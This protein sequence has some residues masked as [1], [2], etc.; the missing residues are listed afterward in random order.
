MR[1]TKTVTMWDF[2]W[3]VRRSGNEAEYLDWD[4][5]IAELADRD[6]DVVRI[7]AFPH[8]IAHDRNGNRQETYTILPQPAGFMWGNHETVEVDPGPQL[9]EFMR[10]VHESGRTAALSTWF[11]DDA[12]NRAA[13]IE[14]PADYERIWTETL[15]LLERH[16]LLDAIEYVDLCNE[17]PMGMFA[18][19]AYPLIFGTTPD[20]PSPLFRPWDDDEL[21]SNAAYFAVIESLRARWPKLRFTFSFSPLPAV[22][23]LDL[24][25]HDV[26]DLHTWLSTDDPTFATLTGFLDVL[27]T[28]D[29]EAL[30]RHVELVDHH[31]WDD[32]DR[33][34][35]TLGAS[36]EH[37]ASWAQTRDAPLWTTEGWASVL[38]NP[39]PTKS[40]RDPWAYVRDMAEFAV[41]KAIELG[42]A[43]IC[44]SNFSQPHFPDMWA[45][46]AWHRRLNAQVHGHEPS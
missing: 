45:D 22:T 39:I 42:W 41:P 2:S 44:T 18:K 43:G 40:G 23:Q 10:R 13:T 35:K 37:W 20:D 8:L 24:A 1:H 5:R 11:L 14:T 27:V 33:W 16:E 15:Q 46:V 19:G 29:E 6:Y 17:W 28:A 30:R 3:L 32:T 25:T 7:D 12:T 26:I 9:V 4:E 31:Y 36:M 38:W 34:Q 21:S